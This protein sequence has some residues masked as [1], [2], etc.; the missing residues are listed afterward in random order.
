M[1]FITRGFGVSVHKKNC[2]NA[3][4]GQQ[5]PQNADRWVKAWWGTQ[6]RESYKAYLDIDALSRDGLVGEIAMAL[7]DMRVPIYAMNA[8]EATK[9][10]ASMELLIGI[11]NTVHL[12]NVVARL[13]KIRDVIAVNR[14]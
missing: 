3:L 11:T 12:N 2:P 8:K 4:K 1:G 5:D 10:R 6:T 14:I 9:G 13:R 7:G